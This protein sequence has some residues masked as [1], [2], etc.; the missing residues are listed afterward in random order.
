MIRPER[1]TEEMYGWWSELLEHS[2]FGFGPNALWDLRLEN[3]MIFVKSPQ[4]SQ[5]M[6]FDGALDREKQAYVAVRG[7]KHKS[8]RKLVPY[9]TFFALN[10]TPRDV[11][12]GGIEEAFKSEDS[13]YVSTGGIKFSNN[14]SF[15]DGVGEAFD[16]NRAARLKDIWNERGG[17]KERAFH[18]GT[19]FDPKLYAGKM[20]YAG[21]AYQGILVRAPLIEVPLGSG[22]GLSGKLFES[23]RRGILSPLVTSTS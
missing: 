22:G 17:R 14:L 4:S 8:Q 21:T 10:V 7:T 16:E 2:G 1:L 23:A 9:V 11:L 15:L 18:V 12:K 19:F 6:G 5:I 3:N 20:A 13:V